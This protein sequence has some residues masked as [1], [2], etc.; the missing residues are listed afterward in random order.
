M[1]EV[2][3]KEIDIFKDVLAKTIGNPKAQ[4]IKDS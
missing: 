2:V 3:T 4:F 1:C